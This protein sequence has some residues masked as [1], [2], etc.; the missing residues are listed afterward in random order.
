L[1]RLELR[2]FLKF[3]QRSVSEEANPNRPLIL[4]A[5]YLGTFEK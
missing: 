2:I 3:F 5:L 1:A 4:H